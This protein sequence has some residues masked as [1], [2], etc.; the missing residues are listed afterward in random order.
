METGCT[1]SVATLTRNLRSKGH[2]YKK[3]FAFREVRSR[4][5]I[6][7]RPAKNSIPRL[8]PSTMARTW[9]KEMAVC[10]AGCGAAGCAR[11]GRER[12]PWFIIATRNRTKNGFN[13][14]MF[15]KTEV[16]LSPSLVSHF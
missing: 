4:E 13:D 12:R 1:Y 10:W 8:D 9:Q 11:A 3:S 15:P 5:R 2:R 6:E 7:R 16:P 14:T